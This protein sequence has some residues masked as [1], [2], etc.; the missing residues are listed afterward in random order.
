MI[1][2]GCRVLCHDCDRLTECDSVVTVDDSLVIELR[3]G[4]YHNGCE[5][6]L[7]LPAALPPKSR[8]DMRVY[9]RLS[10]MVYPLTHKGGRNVLAGMLDPSMRIRICTRIDERGARFEMS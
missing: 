4:A 9:M 7:Y 10:G 3:K 1:V 5:N 2:M 8:H 6:C